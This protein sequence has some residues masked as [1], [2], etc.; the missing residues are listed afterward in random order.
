ML[1][2]SVF[3]IYSCLAH[4]DFL[5]T[6]VDNPLPERVGFNGCHQTLPN[7]PFGVLLPFTAAPFSCRSTGMRVYTGLLTS[8]NCNWVGPD[9]ELSPR[10]ACVV[11]QRA[12]GFD[13][14]DI[15]IRCHEIFGNLFPGPWLRRRELIVDDLIGDIL[16]GTTVGVIGG[17]LKEGHF[18]Q[19]AT[20]HDTRPGASSE[21]R[22][23]ALEGCGYIQGHDHCF[24]KCTWEHD[25]RPG[26]TSQARCLNLRGCAYDSN[27]D[28]CWAS[29][30]VKEITGEVCHDVPGWY[31]SDGPQYNCEWYAHHT[32]Q[33]HWFGSG[34]SNFGHTAN[35]ACC[36][37]RSVVNGRRA[38][39]GSFDDGFD[40]IPK[41]G[42]VHTG[43]VLVG[44]SRE[45]TQGD[46]LIYKPTAAPPA[47]SEVSESECVERLW[48]DAETVSSRELSC[49]EGE[50]IG[51]L[52]RSE[53]DSALNLVYSVEKGY[54]CQVKSSSTCVTRPISELLGEY[55]EGSLKCDDGF[56]LNGFKLDQE[57]HQLSDIIGLKC[58]TQ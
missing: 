8:V 22:C 33:C 43:E 39:D 7:P 48:W 51:A 46:V 30:S 34:Y 17:D 56:V 2:T 50:A 57:G 47:E 15:G 32:N 38:L 53:F 11:Y 27:T 19:C 35:T 9:L 3:F 44:F 42:F 12:F 55:E 16:G 58:C 14:C 28:H 31:D 23:L 21:Q 54:C 6:A 20:F 25:S 29:E 10:W 36:H 26:S 49:N 41:R 5:M 52:F 37:C 13:E 1:F 24:D 4:V 45:M 18:D 40:T